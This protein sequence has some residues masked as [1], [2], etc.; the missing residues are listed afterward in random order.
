MNLPPPYN[1][2]MGSDELEVEETFSP[3]EASLSH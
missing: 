2:I 1:V 3:E